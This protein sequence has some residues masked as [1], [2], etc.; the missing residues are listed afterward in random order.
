MLGVLAEKSSRSKVNTGRS[1]LTLLVCLLNRF[2]IAL[3]LD[4]VPDNTV[5]AQHFE[6]K[7]SNILDKPLYVLS[8]PFP[9][10]LTPL[11]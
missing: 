10:R 3:V 4:L 2:E 7:M 5:A 9:A 1:S 8:G 6:Y 11:S